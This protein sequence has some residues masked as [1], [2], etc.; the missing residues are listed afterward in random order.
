MH[1]GT[2]VLIERRKEMKEGGKPETIAEMELLS[3]SGKQTQNLLRASGKRAQKSMG[4]KGVL[5]CDGRK[6]SDPAHLSW[7]QNGC[8]SK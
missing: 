5:A 6:R 4:K 7:A 8:M 1:I 2:V 3:A